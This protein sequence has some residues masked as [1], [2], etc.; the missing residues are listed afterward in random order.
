MYFSKKFRV[1]L[2]FLVSLI[3]VFLCVIF[4]VV[5][6]SHRVLADTTPNSLV[7]TQIYSQGAAS[8][9][10]PDWSAL[11]FAALPAI[12]QDVEVTAPT[13]LAIAHQYDLSRDIRTGMTPDQYLKLGDFQDSLF[14]QYLILQNIALGSQAQYDLS[15]VA[16]NGFNL[17]QQQSLNDLVQAI[18]GLENFAVSQIPPFNSLLKSAKL[19]SDIANRSLNELLQWKPEIGNLKLGTIKLDQF[20]VTDIPGLKDIPLENLQHWQDSLIHQVPGL[21][22]LPFSQFPAPLVAAGAIGVV[23]MV[24]GAKESD[25]VNTISGSDVEGFQVPCRQNCAYTELAGMQTLYGK[26]WISGKVIAQLG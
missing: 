16:L 6:M 25:R 23:D 26:Q 20:S 15:Q 3:F 11:T 22:D 24:Y 17:I 5:E 13:D 8:T 10:V 14:L 21:K 19:G 12:A 9:L 1:F 7:S 2:C 18:P 4:P